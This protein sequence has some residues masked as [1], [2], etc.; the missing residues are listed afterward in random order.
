MSEQWHSAKDSSHLEAIKWHE[1]KL[2]VKFKN[3]SEYHYE[4]VPEKMFTGM[5]NCRS[6]GEFFHGYIKGKFPHKKV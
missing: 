4:G 6:C 3:G 5:C 2:C 1:G